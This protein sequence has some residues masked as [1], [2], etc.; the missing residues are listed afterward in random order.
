[1]KEEKLNLSLLCDFYELTMG[2]GYLKAGYQ[3]RITYFDVFFRDVPD[4]GGFAI[5]AGLDQFIDYVENLRFSE[6]DIVPEGF[7]YSREENGFAVYDNPNAV[8]MGFLQ[9]VCTGTHHQRMDS[10]TV[11]TVLLAAVALDDDALARYGE[12]LTRL[13]VQQIPGW[14]ESAQRLQAQACDRFETR[15][16]GFTAHITADEAG[17]VVFTIPFDKGFTA[18]VL[19]GLRGGTIK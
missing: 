7:V 14:Q 10:G 2:N 15:A 17:I 3:Y 11:G 13:D 8:P 18:S 6:E 9:T 16:D 19:A 4:N 1:M 12:R 5:C